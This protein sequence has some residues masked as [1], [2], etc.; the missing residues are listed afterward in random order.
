MLGI[1]KK[2]LLITMILCNAFSAFAG[3]S[4]TESTVVRAVVLHQ[5]DIPAS[6]PQT[7]ELQVFEIT[8]EDE[9]LFLTLRRWSLATGHQLVWNANKDFPVKKT[10]YEAADIYAAIAL[11]MQDTASSSYPLHACNYRNRV[12]R[13]LHVSQSCISK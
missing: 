3:T 10:R 2:R 13:I 8:A 9:T 1:L 12:I 5:S 6:L 11:V 4:H 7:N